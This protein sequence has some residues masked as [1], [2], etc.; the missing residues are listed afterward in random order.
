MRTRNRRDRRPSFT[1]VEMLVV[2]AII[3]VLVSL[4]AAAVFRLIFT[5]Q[6]A[7]T[8]SE[9][10][11]LEGELVKQ[12]R[13]AADKFRDPKR[14]P[15]PP[16]PGSPL[17][18]A[19]NYVLT[20]MANNDPNVA[21]V[22]WV[23]LRLKQTFPNNI[24]EALNPA[25]MPPLS[26]YSNQLSL[27]GYTTNNTTAPQPWESS[28]CLLMALQRGEDG[29]GVTP[30]VL[31]PSS[32]I[33]N[34]PAPTGTIPALVDGWGNP[35]RFCRW[36]VGSPVLNPNG[37]PQA[38]DN[39]DPTDPSG[40][41]VSPTW[42]QTNGY[43][44]FQQ[45]CHPVP[46]HAAGTQATTYRIYPLIAS[47]GP[48][49]VLGLDKEPFAAG[50]PAVLSPAQIIM[51]QQQAL[52]GLATGNPPTLSLSPPLSYYFSPLPTGGSYAADDLYPTLAPVQ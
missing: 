39:N 21:R 23:K 13:A 14:E 52:N 3:A 12:Y 22:I 44:L 8:K 19:Y 25:P 17:A 37:Q 46:Q 38:G 43:S 36:P 50:I 29:G 35:L 30:E 33:H 41:L 47:A 42:Q 6:S 24:N 16:P 9:L 49:G 48:D 10:S 11:R 20:S 32:F 40:L 45:Y 26:T 18:G 27:L 31:G 7:N 4:T 34:F 5:Q 2:I 1:L 28:A 51:A 15:L